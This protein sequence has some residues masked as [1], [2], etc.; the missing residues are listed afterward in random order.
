MSIGPKVEPNAKLPATHDASCAV[1]GW[2]SGF[3]SG[4]VNFGIIGDDQE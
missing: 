1:T 2:E 4:F 3:K